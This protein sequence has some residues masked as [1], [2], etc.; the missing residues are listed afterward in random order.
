MKIQ[1]VWN[2]SG[3]IN[4]LLIASFAPYP[5]FLLSLFA[6]FLHQTFHTDRVTLS[7]HSMVSFSPI[8]SHN[9]SYFRLVD[10]QKSQTQV[11]YCYVTNTL[12]F[13]ISNRVLRNAQNIPIRFVTCFITR[14]FLPVR[15]LECWVVVLR[16]RLG[17]ACSIIRR[18][19]MVEPRFLSCFWQKNP[20]V[21]VRNFSG[22]RWSTF[23][24][25]SWRWSCTLCGC[26]TKYLKT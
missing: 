3:Y 5:P 20:L 14:H 11:N 26:F 7:R 15:T 13:E 12:S 18:E 22:H 8:M 2:G 24:H 17:R 10:V 6:V 23:A 21:P 4:K 16:L 25:I 1:L 19:N 9:C